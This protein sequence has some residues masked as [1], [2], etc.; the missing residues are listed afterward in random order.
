MHE[1]CKNPECVYISVVCFA[2]L[3]RGYII[4]QGIDQ[5]YPRMMRQFCVL[6]W[7]EILTKITCVGCLYTEFFYC[8]GHDSNR[9]GNLNFCH[10]S[11]LINHKP[12]I[13]TD[14]PHDNR[15]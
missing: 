5:E 6:K 2:R 9:T 7:E 1:E 12:R 11:G 14:L 8:S 3:V 15:N 10:W 13:I 4:K